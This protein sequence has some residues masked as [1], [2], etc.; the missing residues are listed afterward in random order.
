MWININGIHKCNGGKPNFKVN[1]NIR[2]N[3]NKDWLVNIKLYVINEKINNDEAINWMK[4]N[5][6]T[7]FLLFIW[8]FNK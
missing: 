1:L 8:I 2:I 6:K 4:K 7:I 3:N 5:R